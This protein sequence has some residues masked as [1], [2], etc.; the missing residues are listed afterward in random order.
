MDQAGTDRDSTIRQMEWMLGVLVALFAVIWLSPPL[1]LMQGVHLMPLWA[2]TFLETFAIVVAML[3]FGVVWHAYS[4][5]HA[6]NMVILGCAFLAVGLLDFAHVLSY[7]GMPD[8]VTPTSPH[9]AITFWLVARFVAATTL[10][11]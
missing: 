3:L 6:G 4:R 2:H 8:F 9:K 11:A 10:L 5:Q 1:K 7:R